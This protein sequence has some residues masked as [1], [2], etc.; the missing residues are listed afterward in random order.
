MYL[1][2]WNGYLY[3]NLPLELKLL[4]TSQNGIIF[5]L[6]WSFEFMDRLI[7]FFF[8]D[9]LISMI[10]PELLLIDI[11]ILVLILSL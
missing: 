9:I 10:S 3:G 2:S 8:F 5:F 4:S 6:L 7:L 1:K 11:R